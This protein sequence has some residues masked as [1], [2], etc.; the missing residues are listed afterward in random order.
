MA[1]LNV[2]EKLDKDKYGNVEDFSRDMR[3]VFS[4]ATAYN[5]GMDF[6][7]IIS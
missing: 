2:K 6:Y 1:F 3:L 5:T 4:N 7:T